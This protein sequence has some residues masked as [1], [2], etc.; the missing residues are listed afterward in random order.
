MNTNKIDY[1]ILELQVC[2]FLH[3][4]IMTGPNKQTNLV[5]IHKL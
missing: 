3:T 2:I 4:I 5:L 1:A